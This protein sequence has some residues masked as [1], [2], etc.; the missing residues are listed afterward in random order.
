MR[1]LT[2]IAMLICALGA[3]LYPFWLDEVS[4][5][6]VASAALFDGN[7]GFKTIEVPL[8]AGNGPIR[9]FL[10]ASVLVP[11][12]GET[13]ISVYGYRG[14]TAVFTSS[15]RL[16]NKTGQGTSRDGVQMPAF[17]GSMDVTQGGIYR[18]YAIADGRDEVAFKRIELVLKPKTSERP[19]A[20]FPVF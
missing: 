5:V 13:E 2:F 12:A 14:K 4:D 19:L 1:W 7:D 16:S 9:I 8:E 10:Q 15:V 17:A 6:P 18:F 3:I 11:K 20:M